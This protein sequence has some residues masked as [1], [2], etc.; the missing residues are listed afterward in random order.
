MIIH[1]L[2][3]VFWIWRWIL[4][5]RR[6]CASGSQHPSPQLLHSSPWPPPQLSHRPPPQLSL[7]PP[8]QLSLRPPPQLSHRLLPQFSLQK[9]PQPFPGVSCSSLSSPH[10]SLLTHATDF[11]WEQFFLEGRGSISATPID[12]ISMSIPNI[13]WIKTTSRH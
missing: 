2:F 11:P 3:E 5:G 12:M 8:P 13:S 10:L 1:F 9:P 7:R 6:R 4:L